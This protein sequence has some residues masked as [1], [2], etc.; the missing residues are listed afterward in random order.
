MGWAFL[1]CF[2]PRWMTAIG[3]ERGVKSLLGF[4]TAPTVDSAL[5]SQRKKNIRLHSYIQSELTDLHH[6][7][8]SSCFPKFGR[9]L[10][11]LNQG[12]FWPEV[13]TSCEAAKADEENILLKERINYAGIDCL[14]LDFIDLRQD[15][16]PAF[17]IAVRKSLSL[18]LRKLIWYHA[19][20]VA[21]PVLRWHWRGMLDLMICALAS[22]SS[23]LV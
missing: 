4:C 19:M 12:R 15:E 7:E 1:T 13:I 18:S 6:Y 3:V 23:C 10:F 17:L 2:A 9:T 21:G 11:T 5:L 16:L 14:S 20:C 22:G 8:T